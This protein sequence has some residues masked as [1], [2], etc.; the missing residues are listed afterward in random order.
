[1]LLFTKIAT[2]LIYPLSVALG[3]WGLGLLLLALRRP[4]LAAA[5]LVVGFLTLWTAS[6][7]PV[8]NALAYALESRY[9]PVRVQHSPQADAIVLLGSGVREPTPPSPWS[10]ATDSVDRIIH[11]ARLYRAGKAP[12]VIATGGRM[13]WARSQL[14]QADLMGYLLEEWGVP[15]DAIIR[16]SASV[17]TYEN[18]QFTAALLE[19]SGIDEVLVVTSALH[20]PRAMALF[21]SAGIRAIAAPTDFRT[22]PSLATSLQHWLPDTGALELT[23]MAVKEY[24][25]AVVYRWRGWIGTTLE[26]AT[27][28]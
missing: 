24:V 26:T 20:M 15:G 10:D 17:N 5:S 18:V 21:R 7:R 23:N 25:G 14:S 27:E 8:A 2:L 19:G 6:S 13:P 3:L 9:P 22:T 12:R 4:R 1:M 11:T 16:E 28:E